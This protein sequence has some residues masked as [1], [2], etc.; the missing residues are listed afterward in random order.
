MP[1]RKLKAPFKISWH[2]IVIRKTAAC[3]FD[4]FLDGTEV[5]SSVTRKATKSSKLSLGRSVNLVYG[6]YKGKIDDVSIWDRSLSSAEIL[7][8]YKNVAR[9][10]RVAVVGPLREL[11]AVRET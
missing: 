8:L 9:P 3:V 2:H 1:P 4:L 7:Q 11:S 5:I 10:K 6:Y